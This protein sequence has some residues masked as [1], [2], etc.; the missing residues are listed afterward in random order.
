MYP[1]IHSP[2]SKTELLKLLT[3]LNKKHKGKNFSD[4]E[5]IILSIDLMQDICSSLIDMQNRI[6]LLEQDND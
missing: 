5:G 2:K 6:E 1:R 3:K 4:K